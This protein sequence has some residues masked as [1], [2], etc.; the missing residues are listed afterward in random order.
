MFFVGFLVLFQASSQKRHR[1]NNCFGFRWGSGK[2]PN[3]PHTLFALPVG[4]TES[5]ETSRTHYLVVRGVSGKFTNFPHTLFR[6]PVGLTESSE[7]SGRTHYLSCSSG[8]V[9]GE[10]RN[11]PHTLLRVPG[12]FPESTE[13]F[14]THYLV[15]RGVAGKFPNFPQPMFRVPG[16]FPESSETSRTHYLIFRR[17]SCTFRNVSEIFYRS[18]G[19]ASGPP[20]APPYGFIFLI[21]PAGARKRHRTS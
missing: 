12:G 14:R 5:S 7:T 3:F 13:T 19:S 9:D 17:F 10:F 16:G 4:L 1:S 21:G 15:V 2:F 8:G 11:F 20:P 6:V 18:W